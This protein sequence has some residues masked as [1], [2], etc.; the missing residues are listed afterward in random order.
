MSKNKSDAKILTEENKKYLTSFLNYISLDKGL[1]KN[2][3]L[4]YK[5]DLQNYL[6]YLQ[7]NR[8]ELTKVVHID[9]TE[10]L[11]SRK[12]QKLEPTTIFR[13]IES[14]KMLHRFLLVEE[15]IKEDPTVNIN[16]PQ[17]AHKLPSVLSVKEV[18]LLLDQPKLS[19][20]NGYR[21]RA[22]LEVLYATGLRI[23]ELAELKISDV[24]L[25]IGYVRCWGKGG[26]ERVVP[27]GS[28]ARIAVQNYLVNKRN[29]ISTD[30]KTLF[31]NKSKN[32]ISRVSLWKMIKKYTKQAGIAKHVSPHSLR[33]SFATHL[34][35][36]GADLRSVQEM[37]G[38][39]NISTTQIY[40]HLDR[41][42][43]KQMHKK[44]HPR[45]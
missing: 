9:I 25:N 44:Y 37:L 26:K 32:K 6:L 16:T 11:W 23:S 7:K 34:L 40:T 41:E 35:E 36:H 27:L 43:L 3:Q 30:D 4:A 22:I 12:E 1:A 31:L 17:L 18:E 19:Y 38:H 10:F 39:S 13:N 15:Y 20:F 42:H 8:V 28:M 21:D 33:H 5:T 14:I 45:G 24:N 2:T 29:K